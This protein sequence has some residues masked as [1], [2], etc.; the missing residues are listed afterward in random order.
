MG[1]Q[2]SDRLVGRFL[3]QHCGVS[4]TQIYSKMRSA[5]LTDMESVSCNLCGSARSVVVG[6]RD[7]YALPL[8]SVMCRDC[9]LMYLN[10]RPTQASYS[11]FYV[12]GGSEEGVYHI[13]LGF[14]SIEPLLKRHFGRDYVM[15]EST[16]SALA[17]FARAELARA[18]LSVVPSGDV[19]A[20]FD[21]L[22]QQG[23]D[24]VL[25]IRTAYANH[26]YE[27][28]A[29]HIPRGGKIFEIGASWGNILVPWRDRHGSA[30]TGLEPKLE[31]VQAAKSRLGVDLIVGFPSSAAVPE[32]AFD[33]LLIVRTINHMIDPFGDLRHA[34]R[35]LKPG[36]ALLVDISDAIREA[37]YE[38]FEAKVVEIDHPYMFTINTLS[39]MIEK[40]G[41]RVDHREL[42]DVKHVFHPDRPTPEP[43]QIRI[44]ARKTL[45]PVAPQFA[46]PL[47]EMA[48][49]LTN[50][51]IRERTLAL[52][53]E[54]A[55]GELKS[56]K[57]KLR[58]ARGRTAGEQ[59]PAPRQG[60]WMK[61]LLGLNPVGRRAGG[62]RDG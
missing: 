6:R 62:N 14:D 33:A 52:R 60:G 9:G 17:K 13:E 19:R 53:L 47:A 50:E 2:K 1:R 27:Y 41:F 31:A 25:N 32:N 3:R 24:D 46:D 39:A 10:P 55:Y 36:G 45:E 58:K 34:W 56:V 16:R 15:P 43:K 57:A 48:D 18:G 42:V 8:T 49:L 22:E 29:P 20:A 11:R 59:S 61:R 30:V 51:L 5:M 40:A 37:E 7:K 38:G 35:W 54:T 28:F 21:L 23:M 44:V 4:L 26:I 12:E